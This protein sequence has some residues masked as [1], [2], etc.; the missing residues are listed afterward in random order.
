MAR[1]SV[2]SRKL[3]FFHKKWRDEYE[4]WRDEMRRWEE[5]Q[6]DAK[7]MLN[8]IDDKIQ[9]I[10]D[11]MEGLY[12]Q[13]EDHE[14]IMDENEH[15][16]DDSAGGVIDSEQLAD[17][18]DISQQNSMH[19]ARRQEFM[20]LKKRHNFLFKQLKRVSDAIDV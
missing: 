5:E 4:K 8:H 12:D 14:A 20:E 7:A 2:S 19:D 15:R 9:M 16:F 18:R 13:I 17:Q 11:Q 6:H 10:R 3:T 1:Q